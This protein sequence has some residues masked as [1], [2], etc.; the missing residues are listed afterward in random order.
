MAEV[1]RL[2]PPQV[3]QLLAEVLPVLSFIHQHQLLH[4]DIKPTNIIR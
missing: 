1:E 2:S 3:Q 4:R